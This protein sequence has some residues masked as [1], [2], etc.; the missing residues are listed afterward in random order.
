[1]DHYSTEIRNSAEHLIR[2]EFPK[3]TLELDTLVSVDT[4]SPPPERPYLIPTQT[5]VLSFNGVSKI[6]AE[7]RLPTA[8]DI[9]AYP[10]ND[11][12]ASTAGFLITTVSDNT[13]LCSFLS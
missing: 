2:N 7:I 8:D 3:K 1:M 6:R 10:T 5:D 4:S 9:V 11:K 12:D 13:A